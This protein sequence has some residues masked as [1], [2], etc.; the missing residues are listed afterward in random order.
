MRRCPSK[1]LDNEG[2]GFKATDATTLV[3]ARSTFQDLPADRKG[4]E[5]TDATL[6]WLAAV[7]RPTWM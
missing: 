5:T 4:P 7:S 3:T 1:S 2:I 6:R